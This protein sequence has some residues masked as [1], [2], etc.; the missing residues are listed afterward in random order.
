MLLKYLPRCRWFVSAAA[1]PITSMARSI[2]IDP[3]KPPI[4]R[5]SLH[6]EDLTKEAVTLSELSTSN[7]VSV[8]LAHR[9]GRSRS[10]SFLS[11]SR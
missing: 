6:D 7:L 2:S 11:Q 5:Q 3:H 8:E 1:Q 10:F 9:H 4:F